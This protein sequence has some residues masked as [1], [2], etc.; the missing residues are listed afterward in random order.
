MLSTADVIQAVTRQSWF[1]SIDLKDTY[2]SDGA[3]SQAVPELHIQRA[4]LSV[5]G[6]SIW[7]FPSPMGL[8]KVH[9][10]TLV[11]YKPPECKS[12]PIWMI[13]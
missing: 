10:A 12:S 6:A 3:T 1:T 11:R 4:G 7:S 8:H 9:A 2:R 13:D 5:Q